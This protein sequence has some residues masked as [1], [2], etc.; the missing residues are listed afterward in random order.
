M[1]MEVTYVYSKDY[2]K[3]CIIGVSLIV[4]FNCGKMSDCDCFA[5]IL[6]ITYTSKT[7]ILVYKKE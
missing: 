4:N 3:I 6:Q 2:L 5:N 7:K 1:F